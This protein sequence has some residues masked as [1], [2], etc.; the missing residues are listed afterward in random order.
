MVGTHPVA[1]GWVPEVGGSEPPAEGIHKDTDGPD[2]ASDRVNDLAHLPGRSP[3]PA[4]LGVTALGLGH[5]PHL[6]PGSSL[7]RQG[8]WVFREEVPEK[9]RQAYGP[10]DSDVDMIPPL[11]PG[12]DG[13]R[14]PLGPGGHGG[15]LRPGAV[16]P[17]PST[18]PAG[19]AP[20]TR[21]PAPAGA[22]V[23]PGARR[24]AARFGRYSN[25]SPLAPHCAMQYSWGM[26]AGAPGDNYIERRSRGTRSRVDR[27]GLRPGRPGLAGVHRLAPQRSRQAPQGLAPTG[28]G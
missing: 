1:A 10:R 20:V 16:A 22:V 27:R 14:V 25:G 24:P 18:R 9:A 23:R 15:A 8:H 7:P 19:E 13:G 6:L 26:G 5:G 11:R 28:G 12:Q 2:Q 3:V 4:D 17:P 21:R